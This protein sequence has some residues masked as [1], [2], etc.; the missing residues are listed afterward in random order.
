MIKVKTWYI[1]TGISLHA[2]YLHDGLGRRVRW[3]L[4]GVSRNANLPSTEPEINGCRPNYKKCLQYQKYRT[5]SIQQLSCLMD[6]ILN[7][8]SIPGIGYRIFS[9]SQQCLRTTS[10]LCAYWRLYS[11]NGPARHPLC[12]TRIKNAWSY[13]S[14]LHNV[15]VRVV[16]HAHSLIIVLCFLSVFSRLRRTSQRTP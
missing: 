1:A 3:L 14:I 5:Q 12:S 7:E 13:A 11:M 6:A 2:D 15:F 9:S 16:K 8:D 4:Y 10:I